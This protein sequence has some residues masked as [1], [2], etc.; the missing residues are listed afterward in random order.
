MDQEFSTANLQ[1]EIQVPWSAPGVN[2]AVVLGVMAMSAASITM[3][4][5]MGRG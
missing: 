5:R 4:L 1:L 3:V 2:A